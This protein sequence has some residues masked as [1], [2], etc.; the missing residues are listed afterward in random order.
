ML[1]VENERAAQNAG[2]V[3]AVPC[4]VEGTGAGAP[5]SRWVPVENEEIAL[6]RAQ[7]PVAHL[8]YTGFCRATLQYVLQCMYT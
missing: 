4:S 1:V 6:R 3:E 5:P 7:T 8:V 2:G